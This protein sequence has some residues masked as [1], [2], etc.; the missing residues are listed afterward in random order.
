MSLRD[1][2][3]VFF[4]YVS[5]LMSLRTFRFTPYF[6]S[7]L[8]M[9]VSPRLALKGPRSV[10][11]RWPRIPG[12]SSDMYLAFLVRLQ[13]RREAQPALKKSFDCQHLS[14]KIHI[15]SNGG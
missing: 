15:N 5:S 12:A 14:N 7:T 1:F 4:L 9:R 13:A 8:P 6:F 10:R 2:W 11:E 3:P